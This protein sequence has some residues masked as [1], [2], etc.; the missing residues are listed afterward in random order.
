MDTETGRRLQREYLENRIRTAH[1]LELVNML[2]EVAIDNLNAAIRHLKTQDRLARSR[3]VTRA[4]QA[5]GELLVSLDHSVDAP[6]TRTLAGL[7][8]YCLERTITGHATQS[9]TPF[10]EALSVLS[11]LAVAWR[12]IKDQACGDPQDQG[13]APAEEPRLESQPTINYRY[14]GYPETTATVGSRDWNC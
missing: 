5:L 4:E 3:V 14:A 1:P 9:E 6:F 11:T 13:K 8:K 2:Y 10:R 12:E 7:Y